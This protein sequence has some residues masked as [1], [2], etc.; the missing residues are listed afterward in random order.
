M[1]ILLLFNTETDVVPTRT[2]EDI[3]LATDLSDTLL[4]TTLSSLVKTKV[5]ITSN[6][7]AIEKDTKFTVAK[8]FKRCARSHM[9]SCA[10]LTSSFS[11]RNRVN[12]NV[13]MREETQK[14]TDDTLAA[15]EEDRKLQIQAAI[16]RIMKMRKK[17]DYN[18]LM[19]EV[20][21]QL[22]GRFQAKPPTIKKCI[23]ILI[24]KEYAYTSRVALFG[25]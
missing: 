8:L 3:R 14:V 13:P 7:D 17:L 18:I 4:R 20:I 9:S 16:V 19:T 10:L 6:P 12:I 22:R 23:D 25:R 5:L 24:E 21:T 15:V 1:A 11:K 2:T